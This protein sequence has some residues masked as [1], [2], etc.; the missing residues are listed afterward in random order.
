MGGQGGMMLMYDETRR[1]H[2]H[3]IME[4]EQPAAGRGGQGRGAAE[5]GYMGLKAWREGRG[6]ACASAW[7]T[8]TSRSSSS[9]GS[10]HHQYS[11]FSYGLLNASRGFNVVLALIQAMGFRT[12]SSSIGLGSSHSKCVVT[13]LG[14]SSLQLQTAFTNPVSRGA[15]ATPPGSTAHSTYILQHLED[16]EA[17]HDRL[18]SRLQGMAQTEP[19]ATLRILQMVG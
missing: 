15:P 17:R 6:P 19:H 3:I 4:T 7:T 1:L 2:R 13:S 11:S 9:G 14:R 5:G 8:E 10:G 12:H 16:V 18:L